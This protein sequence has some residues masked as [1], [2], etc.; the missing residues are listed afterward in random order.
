M[1]PSENTSEAGAARRAA[2]QSAVDALHRVNP[3]AVPVAALDEVCSIPRVVEQARQAVAPPESAPSPEAMLHGRC[4][5]MQN[6]VAHLVAKAK[7]KGIPA[8]LPPADDDGDRGARLQ[9]LNAMHDRLEKKI[10]YFDSTTKEQRA[11]DAMGM[12]INRVEK[13]V[14]AIAAAL[15]ALNKLLPLLLPAEVKD[16]RVAGE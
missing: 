14:D 13:R 7:A 2:Y 5:N 1:N 15:G 4:N 9:M 6:A 8:E 10:Q 11:I 16:A 12:Q 3:K